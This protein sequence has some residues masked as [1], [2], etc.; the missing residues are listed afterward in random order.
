MSGSLPDLYPPMLWGPLPRNGNG[1]NDGETDHPDGIFFGIG[2]MGP[3][4]GTNQTQQRTLHHHQNRESGGLG[5]ATYSGN[6]TTTGYEFA[7][8]RPRYELT[9]LTNMAY[10]LRE[11]T[12]FIEQRKYD[13]R[14]FGATWLKPMGV[15]KTLQQM[16]DEREEREELARMQEAADELAANEAVEAEAAARAQAEGDVEMTGD[17]DAT[18][19]GEE[20]GGEEGGDEEVGDDFEHDLDDD[21]PEAM[22]DDDFPDTAGDDSEGYDEEYFVGGA[23]E[24][25]DEA[26]SDDDEEDVVM[27]NDEDD[28]DAGND[29]EDENIPGNVDEDVML[30]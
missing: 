10:Q 19:N 7:P 25:E 27:G 24:D 13:I 12:A 15:T 11:L 30:L 21:I 16:L 28:E 29:D 6:T 5:V 2:G 8:E 17:V 1:I 4:L 3:N 18:G 22:S 9:N 14:M 23:G 26:G 20:E